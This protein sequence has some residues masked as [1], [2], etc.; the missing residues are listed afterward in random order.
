LYIRTG[1]LS[2]KTRILRYAVEQEKKRSFDFPTP[3]TLSMAADGKRL[4]G[5]SRSH[6]R[7]D[8]VNQ[9]EW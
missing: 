6:L 8:R 5:V 7:R 4:L 9:R 3:W 1:I 2:T